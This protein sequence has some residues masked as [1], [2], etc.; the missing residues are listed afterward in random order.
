MTKEEPVQVYLPCTLT[1]SICHTSFTVKVKI[2]LRL[3]TQRLVEK[4]TPTACAFL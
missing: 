1:S 3:S 2:L 4:T